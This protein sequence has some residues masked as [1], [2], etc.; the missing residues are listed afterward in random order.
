MKYSCILSV[1]LLLWSLR[2]VISSPETPYSLLQM[3]LRRRSKFR[4]VMDYYVN[5]YNAGI[6]R[7][8]REGKEFRN[9]ESKRRPDYSK[10]P[11]AIM[12]DRLN[13]TIPCWNQ[14][15]HYDALE[16]TILLPDEMSPCTIYITVFTAFSFNFYILQRVLL[17]G[18]L[19]SFS[20][21]G[22][23]K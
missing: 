5:I 23:H 16:T 15:I 10:S 11:W 22:Q 12:L 4:L 7:R 9:R 14:L 8:R 21:L 1:F 18:F 6:K 17:E 3:H 13:Q 19:L 2:T 20:E